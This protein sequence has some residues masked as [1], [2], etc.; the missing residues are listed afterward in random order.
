M[1]G[2][3]ERGWLFSCSSLVIDI[4]GVGNRLSFGGV[5]TLMRMASSVESLSHSV[6]LLNLRTAWVIALQR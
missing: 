6:C 2:S 5:N 3:R 1:F 4:G